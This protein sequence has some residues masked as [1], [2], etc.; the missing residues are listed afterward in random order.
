MIKF[1][2]VTKKKKKIW[3]H[4]LSWSQISEHPDRILIPGVLGSGITNLLFSLIN[5]QLH[6]DQIYLFAKDPFEAKYQFSINKRESTSLK[7]LNDSNA[8][9]ENSNDMDSIKKNVKYQS[10][11]IVIWLLICLVIKSLIQ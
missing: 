11:I 8:F 3:E 10:F 4:N 5:Q 9:N 2:D 1:D 7:H 6:I